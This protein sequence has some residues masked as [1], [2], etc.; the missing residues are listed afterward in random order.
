MPGTN[1]CQTSASLS[2]TGIWVSAPASSNRHRVTPSATL[3][4]I[5]KFVPAMPRRVPGVAPNGNG[6]PGS[7]AV[8]PGTVEETVLA[9][10]LDTL[11]LL[12]LYDD[13]RAAPARSKLRW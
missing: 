5:A 6:L 4:A 12:R 9:R 10:L 13:R 7:V 8:T 1:T 3:E 11:E 2:R